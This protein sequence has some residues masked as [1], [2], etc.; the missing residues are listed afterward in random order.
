MGYGDDNPVHSSFPTLLQQHQ[1]IPVQLPV[2]HEFELKNHWA[3]LILWFLNLLLCFPSKNSQADK[4]NLR[5]QNCCPSL[6]GKRQL[7]DYVW[8]QSLTTS[9][10]LKHKT[11]PHK[12]SYLTKHCKAAEVIPTRP[13]IQSKWQTLYLIFLTREILGLSLPQFSFYM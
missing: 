5:E 10:Q 6:K 11:I 2:F 7:W 9:W 8:L 13:W 3:K 12:R 1:G 4:T